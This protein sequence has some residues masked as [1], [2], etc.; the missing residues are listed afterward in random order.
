MLCH[1]LCVAGTPFPNSILYA[2]ESLANL[3]HSEQVNS[4][5]RTKVFGQPH[6]QSKG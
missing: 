3:Y 5:E 1:R 4:P 6:R 2:E